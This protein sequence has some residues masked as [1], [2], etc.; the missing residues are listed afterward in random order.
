MIDKKKLEL[1][2]ELFDNA[3]SVLV[4]CASNATHDS[5]RA[6]A[7]LYGVLKS[8][9]KKSVK[10]LYAKKASGKNKKNGSENIAYLDEAQGD[11]GHE[12]LC[13]SL[14]YLEESVDKVSYHV[15]EDVKKFYLTI[16]PK[17]GALPLS[18][19][20]VDFSY[21]GADADMIILV[22]VN[23]LESLGKLYFG[24]ESL[25]NTATLVSV[26][27]HETSFGNLKLDVSGVSSFSEFVAWL[28]VGL[29]V[30]IDSDSA[31]NLLAGIDK[32][33]KGFKSYSAT[34]DTFEVVS[35][36]IRAGARR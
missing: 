32:K 12:N 29:G 4:V 27:S 9:T 23:D 13:I 16:K 19:K 8:D 31:T 36:L 25:F 26:N 2:K 34:A 1:F 24:Y 30:A 7:S 18:N 20:N 21:T 33:T 35:K 6:A 17:K 14:D 10:L 3:E 28:L 15:N 11:I 22:G 5:L